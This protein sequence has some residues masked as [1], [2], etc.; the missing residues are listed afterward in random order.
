MSLPDFREVGIVIT[1]QGDEL[2]VCDDCLDPP[3]KI[4]AIDA[5]QA[6]HPDLA[7]VCRGHEHAA[8]THIYVKLFPA[9]AST[10]SAS[11]STSSM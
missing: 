3:V 9:A 10:T 1:D 8:C 5:E 2:F 4:V 11:T 6:A 7:H